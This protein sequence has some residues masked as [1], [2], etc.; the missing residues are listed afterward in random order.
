MEQ[1]VEKTHSCESLDPK[2]FIIHPNRKE[3]LLSFDEKPEHEKQA[4]QRAF[5]MMP[6]PILPVLYTD[7]F[8]DG[9]WKKAIIDGESRCHYAIKHGIET[10]P[11]VKIENSINTKEDYLKAIVANQ[12]YHQSTHEQ[13]KI[14]FTMWEQMRTGQGKK[15][16]EDTDEQINPDLVIAGYLGIRASRVQKVRTVYERNKELLIQVDTDENFSLNSAY[17]AV[18]KERKLNNNEWAEKIENE[19]EVT[20]ANCNMDK[21]DVQS[22]TVTELNP[23]TTASAT[24]EEIEIT[25]DRVASEITNAVNSDSI[26]NLD[27]TPVEINAAYC[28]GDDHILIICPC[29][30]KAIKINQTK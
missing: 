3:Y 7:L 11:A 8:I 4:S 13:G 26:S 25:N 23:V 24:T 15:S 21:A 28:A 12:N 19:E 30:D 27:K 5:E 6:Q 17:T 29:C 18:R 1:K 20:V 2:G 14:A 22:S 10:I 9:E 16:I